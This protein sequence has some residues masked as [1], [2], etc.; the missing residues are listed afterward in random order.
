MKIFLIVMALVLNLKATEVFLENSRIEIPISEDSTTVIRAKSGKELGDG[1]FD[2]SKAEGVE[3]K[4]VWNIKP[5]QTGD[6]FDPI[7][8]VLF[9]KDN[10]FA[11]SFRLIPKPG[12]K[13]N[14]IILMDLEHKKSTGDALED[15]V[16]VQKTIMSE[17]MGSKKPIR[18]RNRKGKIGGYEFEIFSLKSKDYD[19]HDSIKRYFSLKKAKSIFWIEEERKNAYFFVGVL[20]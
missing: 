3:H 4:G 13:N 15:I 16:K 12:V 6:K 9:F 18:D 8:F 1:V 5:I 17:F 19:N 10:T 20:Q 2:S 7:D 11:Q 14:P